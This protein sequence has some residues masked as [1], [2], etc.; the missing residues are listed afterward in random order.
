MDI[1][2]RKQG[3]AQL[4]KLKGN[5]RLGPGAD[6]LKGLLDELLQTDE[7]RVILNLAEVP[8]MDSSGIGVLVRGLTVMKE[9]GGTI[10]LVQPSKMVLQTLKLVAVLNLFEVFDND[11]AAV[12][13]FS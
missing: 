11:E 12:E 1:S 4:V 3:D 6:G 5:L 13:S 8:S 2:V 10:K 7:T 9:H